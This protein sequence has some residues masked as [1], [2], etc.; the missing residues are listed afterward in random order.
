MVK[1]VGE[2][3]SRTL[4]DDKVQVNFN[5]KKESLNKVKYIA[6]KKSSK[7]DKSVSNSDIYNEAMEEY[8]DKFE[9]KEGK[10]KI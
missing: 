5:I 7:S 2:K 6:L 10:I 3:S 4:P 9:R 1:K 8:I